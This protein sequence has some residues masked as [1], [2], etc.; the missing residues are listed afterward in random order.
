MFDRTG[1]VGGIFCAVHETTEKVLGER[2]L[3]TLSALGSRLGERND[4]DAVVE[5]T[6]EVCG[7]N[8]ADLRFVALYLADGESVRLRGCTDGLRD[9]LAPA[10][11]SVRA[12]AD[13]GA[14]VGGAVLLEDCRSRFAAIAGRLRDEVPD[15]AL[16][17]PLVGG[18]GS[19]LAGWMLAGV[20]PLLMLDESYR[21][22][23]ELVAGHVGRGVIRS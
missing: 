22:F 16:L 2:R 14:G 8:P 11:R 15:T 19:E 23:L 3:G 10:A 21:S 7:S 13:Q 6:V 4:S 18:P 9:V 5:A 20:S 1:S 12:W 17:M